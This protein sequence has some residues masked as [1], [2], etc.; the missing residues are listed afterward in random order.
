[1]KHSAVA[2]EVTFCAEEQLVSVTDTRGIITYANAQFCKVAGYT[3]QELEG[4]NHNIVRH[5]DMPA[6]AFADLWDKLNKGES[7]RG[8]VKNRCKNGDFYWVDA[9]VTP[10]YEDGK[11][12]A[13]QSVRCAPKRRDIENATELYQRINQNKPLPGLSLS[14]FIKAILAI[15]L[16]GGLIA[17]PSFVTDFGALVFSQLLLLAFLFSLYFHQLVTVPKYLAEQANRYDSASRLVFCGSGP[18][19]VLEYRHM[20]NEAKIRTILGRSKDY[21]NVLLG[22]SKDLEG[23]SESMLDGLVEESS[24]L[25]QLG[26]AIVEMSSTINEIGQNTVDTRDGVDNIHV[27]CKNA[28]GVLSTSK[29]RVEGLAIDVEEASQATNGLMSDVAKITTLMSEIQGIADQTN[30]LALNAAIEAARAG[31]MG[32]GFAVVAD[33][34]RTLAGR[35]QTAT[36][37]IQNSVVTLEETLATWG[38]TMLS[39]QDNAQLCAL[40]SAKVTVAM[41]DILAML[42]QMAGLTEQVATATEEQSV[43]ANEI[44]SNVHL[45]DE[46]ANNNKE[47]ASKVE[48]ASHEVRASCGDINHL[49]ETFT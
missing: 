15:I 27:E 21:S 5:P 3:A 36:Q 48:Q 25:Q 24:Q 13:F 2:K 18:T 19:A 32:R 44:K 17:A 9:Y 23:S 28:I 41:N 40:D 30:L 29:Q 26:T 6:A 37:T 31:E 47:I 1:M 43:V 8:I 49:S 4:E 34:V 22:M 14:P 46:I 16:A 20:L 35:T 10:L 38:A 11:V 12:T 39:N 45:V 33:E 42:D 7:W